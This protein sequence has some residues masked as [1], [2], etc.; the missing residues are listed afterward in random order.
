M[1]TNGAH[2]V[3]LTI[4]YGC[5]SG[6]A[7]LLDCCLSVTIHRGVT[8]AD[9]EVLTQG[10]TQGALSPEFGQQLT[11]LISQWLA[12][13]DGNLKQFLERLK[14]GFN[15]IFLTLGYEGNG[16]E[17]LSYDHFQPTRLWYQKFDGNGCSG[18]G[19]R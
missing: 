13:L 19:D 11:N 4:R 10:M 3:A 5:W 2:E 16:E 12:P 8:L 14:E 6:L 18:K 9:L 7:R 15:D 17:V 1:V